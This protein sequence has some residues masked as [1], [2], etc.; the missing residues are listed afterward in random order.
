MK[1]TIKPPRL[2]KNAHIRVIAPASPPS[3]KNL[4]LG[5]ERFR[6]FGFKVSFGD[7]IKKTKQIG[8]LSAPDTER[9]KELI[10]AFQDD[11]VDAIFC[12]RGGYGSMRILPLIDYEIIEK[13]PKIFV[14]YSDITALHIA[15]NKMTGLI[16]FHSLMPGAD[17]DY[18]KDPTINDTNILQMFNIMSGETMDITPQIKRIVGSIVDGET[19]GVSTGTNF[20]LLVSLIGTEYSF[21]SSERILFLE[22]VSTSI[23][24]IDRYMAELWLSKMLYRAKGLVF[25]DFTQIPNDEVPSPSLPEIIYYYVNKMKKPVIYGMPF[26]HGMDQMTIPLDAKM[27]ISTYDPSIVLQ[28]N[29]VD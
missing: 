25:G 17:F 23:S 20:S 7:N 4:T 19:S 5:V 24:D 2:K 29:V 11:N 3:L 1:G 9:A 14:G 10:A 28:E 13:H 16:T 12:A 8:Y 22:D 15:I 27:K 18:S 21:K 6:K 26:G